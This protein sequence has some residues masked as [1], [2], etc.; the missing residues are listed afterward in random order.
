MISAFH[1]LLLCSFSA[2]DITQYGAVGDGTTLN[3]KAIQ[4]A[5]DAAAASGGGEVRFPSGTYLTGT[6][7]LKS[8]VH[9]CLSQG[10]LVL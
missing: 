7:F 5:I 1:V 3:T 6:L 8:N 4:A 9:L 10:T 2:F